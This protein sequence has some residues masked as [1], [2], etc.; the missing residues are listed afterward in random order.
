MRGCAYQ[1]LGDVPNAVADTRASLEL[2]HDDP[3]LEV[4][5]WLCTAGL[6]EALI[7]SGELAAAAAA[8]AAQRGRGGGDSLLADAFRYA[9]GSYALAVGDAPKALEA[10][11]GC[12]Q[13]MLR[14]SARGP[15]LMPWRSGKARAL[16]ALD[17]RDEALE[18][19]AE[20][21]QVT[22]V[23]ASDR[24]RGI[25]LATFG[26]VTGGPAGAERLREAIPVLARAGAR[27]EHA[28][29]LLGLGS[30]LRRSGHRR[31]ARVSLNEALALARASGAFGLVEQAAAELEASGARTRPIMRTGVDALT[32]SERRVAALA[33]SGRSNREIASSLFVTI[34]TVETHLSHSYVKLGVAGRTEL[35]AVLSP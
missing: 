11:A 5:S 26:R 13:R 12:Q 20:D 28:R 18:V 2:M 24:A 14:W 27:T 22:A 8:L 32:P 30:L 31:E 23:G 6:V 3:E 10:F 21:L 9:D 25:A 33:A 4:V 17:R 34:R 16:A 35:A 1:R 19:V 15:P 7:D 29:A